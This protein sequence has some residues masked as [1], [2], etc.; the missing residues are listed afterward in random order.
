[1]A[2]Y[3]GEK[4]MRRQI[5]SILPQLDE[6]DELVLSLDPSDDASGDIAA[7]FAAGD[8]RVRVIGGPGE[9]AIKNF[10]NVLRHVMGDYIFLSDQDD[11]WDREKVSA[12]ISELG[13]EGVLAVVHD[14]IVTDEELN[15]SDWTFFHGGFYS[16]IFKN[17]VRNRYIG[18]C[19]AFKRELLDYSLP[20]PE[21][22][23]MHDQW[24]GIAAKKFGGVVFIDKPL[25][26]YRRHQDAATGQ[27]KA[28][29]FTQIRWRLQ[30]IKAYFMLG[31]TAKS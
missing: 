24:L 15:M 26:K 25:I 30:I 20:F 10:E 11:V 7:E 8:S 13:K 18:C 31:K 2:V 12:C 3:N 9:G 14:A 29:F 17:I 21:K 27:K 5:E 19:M 1:M 23:P 6:N 28:S 22:L 4:Y 16:G